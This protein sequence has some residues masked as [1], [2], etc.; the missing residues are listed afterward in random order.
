V[1]GSVGG[2][3][4]EAGGDN[5]TDGCEDGMAGEA[6]AP[7][8][9]NGTSGGGSKGAQHKTG[10]LGCAG[11]EAG[12]KRSAIAGG[13][14]V[15]QRSEASGA[16]GA[17]GRV[18]L[19][20]HG[21]GLVAKAV[22]VSEDE[23]VVGEVGLSDSGVGGKGVVGRQGGEEGFGKKVAAG[24]VGARYVGGE[25][26]GVEVAGAQAGK[27]SS[28]LVLPGFEI[29]SREGIAQGGEDE[30]QQIGRKGWDDAEAEAAGEG[31]TKVTGKGKDGVGLGH[32]GLDMTEQA[33]AGLG[34]SNGLTR[35]LKQG[36]AEESLELT[37]LHGESGLA[38]A[39]GLCGAAEMAVLS[40]GEE[41]AE[42]AQVHRGS[43]CNDR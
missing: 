16:Q 5:V 42:V 8:E 17:T 22:A 14:H 18:V 27:K 29:E 7:G 26:G 4:T 32:G 38:D 3:G 41:V 11:S 40:D 2:E 1:R 20:T 25:Q 37:D 12:D 23:D 13:N 30:G 15:E 9:A 19:A 6:G 43:I 24:K 28:G 10:V 39:T 36:D 21:K 31:V 33:V 35:A 34:G